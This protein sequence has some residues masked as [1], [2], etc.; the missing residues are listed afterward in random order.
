MNEQVTSS[1]WVYG[2]RGAATFYAGPPPG[3]EGQGG[4]N[5]RVAVDL[6]SVVAVTELAF[7]D[8]SAGCA[9]WTSA[10]DD[11]FFAVRADFEWVVERWEAANGMGWEN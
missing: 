6:R 1:G 8:G 9:L 3:Y 11:A 10:Q 7:Q 5:F 2:V 4:G